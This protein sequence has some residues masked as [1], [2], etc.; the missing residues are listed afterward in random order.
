MIATLNSD[1]STVTLYSEALVT[2][3]GKTFTGLT[4]KSKLNC[5]STE[6]SV[7]LNSLLG[8]ISNKTITVPATLFYGDSS[9]TTFC[10]GVYYFKLEISYNI[11]SLTVDAFRVDDS[12][13]KLVDCALKCDLLKYYLDCK[14]SSLYYWHYALTQGSSCDSCTCTEMCTLYTEL[15]NKLYGYSGNSNIVDSSSGCGCS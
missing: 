8:S 4:L 1:C 6:T 2:T 11:T 12:A 10:D 13:C 9:K 5:S 14:D 15:K 7:N 3:A